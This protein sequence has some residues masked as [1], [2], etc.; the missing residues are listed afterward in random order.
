VHDYL[1][2]Q[3]F[4]SQNQFAGVYGGN[5]LDDDHIKQFIDSLC[6]FDKE[7]GSSKANKKLNQGESSRKV[8]ATFF[9][10]E[11]VVAL[12]RITRKI[13]TNVDSL[14]DPKNKKSPSRNPFRRM[15]LRRKKKAKDQNDVEDIKVVEEEEMWFE[16][17]DSLPG[18]SMLTYDDY[19]E[20]DLS[21]TLSNT[22]RIRCNSA[23]SLQACLRWYACS[24]FTESD[25]KF[26]NSYQWDDMNME[27][28]PRVF[29]AFVWSN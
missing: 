8:A 18:A 7:E 19:R 4:L 16:I 10:H 5:I 20:E 23:K 27:F 15:R 9:F 29:Q 25:K 14:D 17:I 2:E 26:I 13:D 11:H 28:D 1:I 21:Y 6:N 22:A 3:N 24:K 12:H